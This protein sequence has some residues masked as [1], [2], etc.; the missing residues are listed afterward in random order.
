MKSFL[1]CFKNAMVFSIG[2]LVL[3]GL[4]YPT[5]L[6]GASQLFFHDKAN[7]SLIT[8]EDRTIGSQLVG[9]DFS[10]ARLFKCRPS[11]VNYNTYTE[12]EKKDGSYTGVSSGSTNYAATN[13]A[14][15]ERVEEDID[16][17][18]KANPD[19]QKKDLPGDLFTASGSG[20]DPHISPASAKIQIPAIAKASG[21][22][23]EKL[24]DIVERNTQQK[25]FGVF[26]EEHVNVLQCNLEIARLINMI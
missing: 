26:G 15:K 5:L 4:L 24:F 6:T 14:L 10:D 8:Y 13:P 1:R 19:V 18:L 9:Q 3:C 22:S 16:A 23:E 2:M 20:L 7:G 17:F 21:L 25:A 12:S 11:A